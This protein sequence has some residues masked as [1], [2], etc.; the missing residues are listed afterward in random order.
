[1]RHLIC[2][3]I[4]SGSMLAS[5][6]M[7]AEAF[8]VP[9]VA[10]SIGKAILKFFGKEGGEQATE[11]LSRKG[12]QEVME[13]VAASA[14]KQ[15]GEEAVEQVAKLTGKYG[16]EALA[17]LDNSPSIMPVLRALDELPES[18]I[19]PALT[20]LAAGQPGRELAEAIGRNGVAALRTEMQHPGVGLFFV[21]SLGDE[22]VELASKLNADQAIVVARHTD[23]IAKLPAAQRAGVL[24]LLRQDTEQ[25]V[26]F[27]GRFVE[28]NPGKTLFSVAATTVILAQP[29][30]ILGGD[31]IVFDADGNPVVVRKGG[32]ADRTFEAGG[33]VASHVSE[34]YVRPVYLAV[35]S[36]VGVF[37]VMWLGLKYWQ[38]R[39]LRRATKLLK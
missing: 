10:T 7:P 8:T 17:A 22:G 4:L 21:R 15:G 27:M 24:K 23:E 31:E 28:K 2:A 11:Y 14:A 6:P 37:T 36:F 26:G 34:K 25:M 18:Q 1:M 5:L 35:V 13:R 38:F 3:F 33:E 12:G 19:K 39:K 9:A 30:R 32:I 20:R 29:E 16:P